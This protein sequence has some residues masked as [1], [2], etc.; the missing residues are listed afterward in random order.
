MGKHEFTP[1]PTIYFP[2]EFVNG[3]N[4]SVTIGGL[5]E[6]TELIEGHEIDERRTELDKRII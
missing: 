5:D 1:W 6:E 4:F 2:G 3:S